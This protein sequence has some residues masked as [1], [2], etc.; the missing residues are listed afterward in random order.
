[1]YTVYASSVK[2]GSKAGN[3][4]ISMPLI[5]SIRY[6]RMDPMWTCLV[7]GLHT[8]GWLLGEHTLFTKY[9]D[10]TWY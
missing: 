9:V 3:Q 4:T 10:H 2:H 7:C 8:V 5:H 6:N 1:M